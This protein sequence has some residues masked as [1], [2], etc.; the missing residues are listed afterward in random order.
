MSIP[1]RFS[2]SMPGTMPTCCG[3]VIAGIAVGTGVFYVALKKWKWRVK[4]IVC[5]G[6]VSFLLY[7]VMLYFLIDAS[8]EKY[9]LYLPMLF[10]GAGV[11]IVYTSLAYALAGCVT[12]CLL[13]RGD[14]CHR[15]HSHEFRRPAECGRPHAAAERHK[16]LRNGRSGQPCRYDAPDGRLVHGS[17]RG[18]PAARC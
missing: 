13:F 2:D 3:G 18:V 9:M 16:A 12:V 10:K 1:V 7:Q 4:S 8:T 5:V 17:V 14:V 11:S 15:F 6:F